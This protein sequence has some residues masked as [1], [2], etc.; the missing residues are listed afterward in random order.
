MTFDLVE[1]AAVA[2]DEE[3]RVARAV[4]DTAR[5]SRPWC[6]GFLCAD[7]AGTWANMALG[8]AMRGERIT[9]RDVAEVVD[10]YESRG[11]EPHVQACAYSHPSLVRRLG[12]AGFVLKEMELVLV[13]NPAVA[14]R[15]PWECPE[16][17]SIERVPA[18]DDAA[19]T[20]FA[21]VVTTGFYEGRDD[22]VQLALMER[23]SR[24]ERA[25]NLLARIEG[26]PVGG[27]SLDIWGDLGGLY[28]AA[29]LPDFRRRGV[30]LALMRERLEIAAASGCRL[31][32]VGTL[33]GVAT[34]RNARRCG[35]TPCYTR[36]ALVRPGKGLTPSE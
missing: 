11:C 24:H 9:G 20:E 25:V 13:V 6:G 10:W 18:G 34:E 4:A 14:L 35:M 2:L 8:A 21:R 3:T 17:L 27:A 1:P 33:P 36:V 12:E 22:A 30:Q 5:E 32:T 28:F 15:I 19:V 31:A 23:A 26:E 29:V 7:D 16:H